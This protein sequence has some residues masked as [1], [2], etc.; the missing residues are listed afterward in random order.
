MIAQEWQEI[1]QRRVGGIIIDFLSVQV[2]AAI[3]RGSAWITEQEATN[4]AVAGLC[5]EYISKH[6]ERRLMIASRR[7]SETEALFL[8]LAQLA[9]WLEKR[10]INVSKI[11]QSILEDIAGEQATFN[12]FSR[13]GFRPVKRRAT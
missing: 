13:R 3:K 9:D 10:D 11:S 6:I 4:P 1:L 2:E 8:Q 7:D 12:R 5:L